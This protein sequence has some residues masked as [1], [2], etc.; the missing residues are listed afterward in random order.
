MNYILALGEM[1]IMTFT[2]L[3]ATLLVLGCAQ[4]VAGRNQ[5]APNEKRATFAVA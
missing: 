3:L 4:A 1:R 5:I 2:V